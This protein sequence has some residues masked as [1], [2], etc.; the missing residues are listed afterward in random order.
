MKKSITAIRTEN[1]ERRHRRIRVRLSGTAERPRISMYRSNSALYLQL[2]NDEQGA[3][4]VAVSTKDMAGKTALARAHAAGVEIAKKAA[5]KGITMAV[6]DRSGYV[7]AGKVKAI[8][9]GAR[10]GGLAF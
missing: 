4:L 7:Y 2:I 5:A 9:E 8:A 3:T 1:R 10:E 6:F